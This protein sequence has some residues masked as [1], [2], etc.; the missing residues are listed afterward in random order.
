[1]QRVIFFPF[2]LQTLLDTG[3]LSFPHF[4][5]ILHKKKALRLYQNGSS[6]RSKR[7]YNNSLPSGT[8]LPEGILPI[9][10]HNNPP[11]CS[12]PFSQSRALQD[13]V[14]QGTASFSS[15]KKLVTESA[16]SSSWQCV[17]RHCLFLKLVVIS[18]STVSPLEDFPS[19]SVLVTSMT[20]WISHHS[21]YQ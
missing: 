2:D 12:D 7:V 6:P 8:F 15:P 1:M 17:S 18:T 4:F 5:S 21:L 19:P 10:S 11:R 20:F 13:N 16:L 14:F 9:R 3:C